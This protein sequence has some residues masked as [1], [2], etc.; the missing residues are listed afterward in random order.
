MTYF[1]TLNI[2]LVTPTLACDIIKRCLQIGVVVFFSTVSGRKRRKKK[3]KDSKDDNPTFFSLLRSSNQNL[4]STIHGRNNCHIRF[5]I[6]AYGESGL[7]TELF[8]IP[9]PWRLWDL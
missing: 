3:E 5:V 9:R 7:E 4:I 6:A 2:I 1:G 8:S